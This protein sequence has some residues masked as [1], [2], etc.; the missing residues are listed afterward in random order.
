MLYQSTIATGVQ[1]NNCLVH[2]FWFKNLNICCTHTLRI[3]IC[4]MHMYPKPHAKRS[5]VVSMHI[6]E[7][8]P[9]PWILIIL[10]RPLCD[11][12][13][14]IPITTWY[15]ESG[16]HMIISKFGAY[17]SRSLGKNPIF[18]QG[19]HS[20]ISLWAFAFW[21]LQTVWHNVV[22]TK[23]K[24]GLGNILMTFFELY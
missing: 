10:C 11:Q 4:A 3:N 17:T 13:Y 22:H 20:A 1:T 23:F 9:C 21:K 8:N 16:W 15:F 19:K 6:Y 12:G 7:K 24:N 18:A 14:R 2:G 5:G